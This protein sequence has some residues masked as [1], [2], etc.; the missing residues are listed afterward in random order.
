MK[1]QQRRQQQATNPENKTLI[2][3]SMTD[4]VE[5]V[6]SERERERERGIV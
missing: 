1:I 2:L 4:E 3:F 6:K 5:S